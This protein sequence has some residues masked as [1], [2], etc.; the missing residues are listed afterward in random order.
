MGTRMAR[1]ES[2]ILL[3]HTERYFF[4]PHVYTPTINSAYLL[5]MVFSGQKDHSPAPVT[6][7]GRDRCAG[8]LPIYIH[9][10][11]EIVFYF[12]FLIKHHNASRANES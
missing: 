6:G 11:S 1:V 2:G 7:T 9:V 8:I 12:I 5:Y 3:V 10:F 4:P